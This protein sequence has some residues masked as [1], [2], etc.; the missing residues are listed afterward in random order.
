MSDATITDFVEKTKDKILP[1]AQVSWRNPFGGIRRRESKLD[2]AVTYIFEE[3]EIEVYVDWISTLH[4]HVRVG[5]TIGD[6]LWEGIQYTLRPTLKPG[7]PRHGKRFKIAQML[8]VVKE[9]NEECVSMSEGILIDPDVSSSQGSVALL[10]PRQESFRK[11][12]KSQSTKKASL[13]L[14]MHHNTEQRELTL[15]IGSLQYALD[16]PTL[17]DKLSLVVRERF[18]IMDIGEEPPLPE[19]LMLE[20]V[21]TVPW[22][23]TVES[24]LTWKKQL[25]EDNIRGIGSFNP[26]LSTALHAQAIYYNLGSTEEGGSQ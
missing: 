9:V 20:D 1:P 17:P 3:E 6:S 14:P 8:P 15:H 21:R 10:T 23:Q 13:N 4:D 22:R 7:N 5:F 2:F 25:L 16:K 19:D 12:L 24:H 18:H 11:R 26:G